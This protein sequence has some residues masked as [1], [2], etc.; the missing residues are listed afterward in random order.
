MRVDNV[1]GSLVR[2]IVKAR[3]VIA[4]VGMFLVARP[5]VASHIQTPEDLRV[6]CESSPGNVVALDE[7]TAIKGVEGAALLPIASGCTL[8]LGP[9]AKLETEFVRVAF[10]GPLVIQS[11][12]PTDVVLVKTRV[13]APALSLLLTGLGSAIAAT[14]SVLEA[15]AGDVTIALSANAKLE[16]VQQ[17]PGPAYGLA[18]TGQVQITS[19][20]GFQGL[21]YETNIYARQGF[22]YAQTILGA[23]AALSMGKVILDAPLGGVTVTTQ[24]G[25]SKLEISESSFRVRD[26]VLMSLEGRWS[27]IGLKQVA[28]GGWNGNT[29]PGGVTIAAAPTQPEGV[30]S[31]SE[32]SVFDVATAS[33]VASASGSVTPTPPR[34]GIVTVEKSWLLPDYDLRVETGRDSS[35][36]VKESQLASSSLIRIATGTGAS[37]CLQEGNSVSGLPVLQLCP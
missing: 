24:A 19:Y 4:T 30:V 5:A 15:T 28:M 31:L 10:A 21:I 7:P 16:L 33:V 6:A 22:R 12:S 34:F 23:G 11:S 9:G 8:V 27:H 17:L 37:T 25:N 26:G 2:R 14:Q 36:V 13:S 35:V 29:A 32:V 3:A 20:S 18:A 1:R